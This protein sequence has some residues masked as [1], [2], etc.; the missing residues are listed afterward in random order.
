MRQETSAQGACCGREAI[1][2]HGMQLLEQPHQAGAV[3]SQLCHGSAAW[4]SDSPDVISAVVCLRAG[5]VG[6]AAVR[7]APD[8]L[9]FVFG[10]LPGGDMGG[11]V[12]S[13]RAAPRGGGRS[14]WGLQGW[15][16]QGR[17][18]GAPC[19]CQAS[20]HSGLCCEVSLHIPLALAPIWCTLLDNA[21]ARP[22]PAVAAR[23]CMQPQQDMALW[24]AA[25]TCCPKAFVVSVLTRGAAGG[26][27]ASSLTC[28][29]Q[30]Q[31]MRRSAGPAQ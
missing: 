30:L 24:Q 10:A 4:Q 22:P 12:G 3:A 11:A 2:W 7:L 29:V 19:G 25:F 26:A 9:V 20:M 6:R 13:R 15:M 23:C 27:A 31:R 5:C 17:S 8:L 21:Q 28:N 16:Q 14:I 18:T 1:G